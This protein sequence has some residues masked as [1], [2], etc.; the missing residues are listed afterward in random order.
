MTLTFIGKNLEQMRWG[1]AHKAERRPKGGKRSGQ[2]HRAWRL[3]GGF[4][5]GQ[6]GT[7]GALLHHFYV[8][9]HDPVNRPMS[10]NRAKPISKNSIA[11]PICWLII[12]VR[13][14][15]GEPLAASVS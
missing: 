6:G 14:D 7:H 10:W 12:S 8:A 2:Q 15:T 5:E 3:P 1:R 4:E 9:R 11:M 13:M